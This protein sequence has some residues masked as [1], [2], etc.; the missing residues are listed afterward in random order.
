MWSLGYRA[1]PR[2]SAAFFF[3]SISTFIR[4]PT[5]GVAQ[6]VVGEQRVPDVDVDGHVPD[7][8]HEAPV[9]G[10]SCAKPAL[11]SMRS[12][13]IDT[14]VLVSRRPTAAPNCVVTWRPRIVGWFLQGRVKNEGE[15]AEFLGHPAA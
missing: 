15:L 5:L 10:E 13:I 3:V 4:T 1:R 11:D 12:S 14:T 6:A 8:M 2:P 7:A 9:Y